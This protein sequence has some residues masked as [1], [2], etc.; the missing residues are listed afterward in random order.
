[1]RFT[2][3]H[4]IPFPRD[5]VWTTIRDR[6]D[7]LLAYLPNVDR[8]EL[9]EHQDLGQVQRFVKRWVGSSDDIPAVLRP[10]VKPDLIQWIDHA[11]WDQSRWLVEWWHETG[12]LRGGM[13]SKGTNRY[14]ADGDIT[15]IT[16][17]GDLKIHPE[18]FTFLP[19]V[20]A[21]RAAPVLERFIIGRLKP[22]L[23]ATNEAVSRFMEDQEY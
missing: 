20:I 4:E 10:M 22:N 15:L 5:L 2:L 12:V 14:E 6:Q 7:D 8:I 21:R 17:E 19:Q 13:T 16:F 3:T 23:R 9:I 11:S 1:M 18:A